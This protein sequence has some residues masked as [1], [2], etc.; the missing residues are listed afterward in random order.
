MSN[1][2][3]CSLTS[4]TSYNGP[5]VCDILEKKA[6]RNLERSIHKLLYFYLFQILTQLTDFALT[7]LGKS[8]EWHDFEKPPENTWQTGMLKR[9][10][11]GFKTPVIKWF[12]SCLSNR[13]SFIYVNDLFS[14]DGIWSCVPILVTL[15]FD[16]HCLLEC[17]DAYS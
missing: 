14:E 16:I 7:G 13:K 12:E 5:S 11:L 2:C 9:W 15:V 17:Q 1:S 8:T 6:K 4:A 10:Y 3:K